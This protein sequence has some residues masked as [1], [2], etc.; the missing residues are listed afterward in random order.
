MHAVENDH[1]L[2]L[3]TGRMRIATYNVE[4]ILRRAR[5]LN[6]ESWNESRGL[7]EAY[8]ELQELMSLDEYPDD[9]R[10][11]MRDLLVALGLEKG[12][13]SRLVT[14]VEH[15][16]DF[17]GVS[18]LR[19]LRVVARHRKDWVGWLEPE[20]EDLNPQATLNQ[21][22]VLR[23]L[24]ADVLALQ[25]VESGAALDILVGRCTA[26]AGGAPFAA[27]MYFAGN[28]NRG[29]GS[30]VA[31]AAG[32]TI[33]WMRTHAAAKDGE[34]RHILDRDAP[35]VAVWT[36]RANVLWLVNA[37]FRSRG[38]GRREV[39]DAR[40]RAQ[41]T[42]V[43]AN[44]RRLVKEGAK[45]VAVCGDL[46]D[47]PDTEALAPLLRDTDLVDV[48]GHATFNGDG[49]VGTY[50]RA[51]AKEK[52][53]YILLS[54]ELFERVKGAGVVRRG[55]W[56]PG[57]VPAWDVYPELKSAYDLASD[58]AALWCDVDLP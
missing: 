49:H 12:R 31:T 54:P 47:Q 28:D 23:D 57:K 6:M 1:V 17:A 32:H 51:T 20:T 52:I 40:R 41:A 50:G 42:L 55:A 43:A 4:N 53:D 58:H 45:F 21:G 25:E 7:L 18:A 48:S 13:R 26:A 11:R 3:I 5:L 46:G 8:A 37:H 44:Y 39:A 19:G 15:R 24:A 30:G 36:P 2:W 14:L 56:G 22:Q 38:Y 35:E 33:G 9:V 29:L 34:G 27:A 16:G 10:R